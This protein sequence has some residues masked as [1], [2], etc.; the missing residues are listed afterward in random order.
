MAPRVVPYFLQQ[1]SMMARNLHKH[2]TE[3]KIARTDRRVAHVGRAHRAIVRAYNRAARHAARL[4]L[5]APVEPQE[6]PPEPIL[7]WRMVVPPDAPAEWYWV[8]EEV[9]PAA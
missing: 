5:L 3:V 6:P 2:Y 4:E 9:N 1:E 8:V 7:V